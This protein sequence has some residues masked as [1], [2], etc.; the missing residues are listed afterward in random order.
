MFLDEYL[1]DYRKIGDKFNFEVR[2]TP[3]KMVE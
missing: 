2:V 1:D 3:V